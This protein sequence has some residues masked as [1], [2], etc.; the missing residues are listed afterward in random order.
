M[1]TQTKLEQI[2]FGHVTAQI[3]MIEKGI[4]LDGTGTAGGGY[5]A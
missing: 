4:E 5:A 3:A 1:S 2:V